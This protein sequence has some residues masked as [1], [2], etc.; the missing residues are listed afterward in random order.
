MA[1]HYLDDLDPLPEDER[2]RPHV[3]PLLP[4][5]MLAGVRMRP[6]LY[7]ICG[8]H[9]LRRD[10]THWCED[11]SVPVCRTCKDAARAA[12]AALVGTPGV[13]RPTLAEAARLI[14][15]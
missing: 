8:R 12:E 9:R 4:L 1:I 11:L 7:G 15:R 14:E 6:G 13:V 2:N 5:L 10:L 3:L